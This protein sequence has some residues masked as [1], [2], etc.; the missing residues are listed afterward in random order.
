MMSIQGHEARCDAYLPPRYRY[1]RSCSCSVNLQKGLSTV[2]HTESLKLGEFNPL[3]SLEQSCGVM[4][5]L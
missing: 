3:A 2:G 4:I 5:G 1:T